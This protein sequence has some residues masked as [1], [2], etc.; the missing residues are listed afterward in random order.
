VR[1]PTTDEKKKTAPTAVEKKTAIPVRKG[2]P[3]KASVT[4]THK[5]KAAP[6]P[7][8]GKKPVKKRTKVD[9]APAAATTAAETD[10]DILAVLA[11]MGV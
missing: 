10:P 6:P 5:A 7:L 9:P 3:K 11:E 1:E 2:T 4:K 8:S